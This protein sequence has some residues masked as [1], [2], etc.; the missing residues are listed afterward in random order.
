MMQIDSLRDRGWAELF[1][2]Y[3]ADRRLWDL[4]AT[5]WQSANVPHYQGKQIKGRNVKTQ[6]SAPFQILI[7]SLLQAPCAMRSALCP[8][9]YAPI[10]VIR[11]ISKGEISTPV[12][13]YQPVKWVKGLMHVLHGRLLYLSMLFLYFHQSCLSHYTVK[14]WNIRDI[15]YFRLLLQTWVKIPTQRA[16]L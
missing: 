11:Q 4:L 3:D 5:W 7:S 6:N 2:W 1:H 15:Q 14:C 9:R 10:S 12:S 16:G 13:S 8:F